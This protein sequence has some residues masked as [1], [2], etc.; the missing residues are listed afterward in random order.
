MVGEGASIGAWVSHRSCAQH[1]SRTWPR[2]HTRGGPQPVVSANGVLAPQTSGA[3]PPA[4]PSRRLG[5]PPHPW[6]PAPWRR[7]PPRRCCC[8]RRRSWPPPPPP[9]PPREGGLSGCSSPPSP[10]ATSRGPSSSTLARRTV[11]TPPRGWATWRTPPPGGRITTPP[12]GR[13]RGSPTWGS[14]RPA[15]VAVV[16]AVAGQGQ[17]HPLIL[18]AVPSHRVREDKDGVE[19]VTEAAQQWR[20]PP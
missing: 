4:P 18:R 16:V 5:T 14:C 9:P 17:E 2:R 7:A 11:P 3:P 6:A 13:R 10:R 19:A 15:A 12:T 1:G 20:H 8:W